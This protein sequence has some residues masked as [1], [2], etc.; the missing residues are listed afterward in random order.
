MASINFRMTD[1]PSSR[2]AYNEMCK[3]NRAID[4][5]I[6]ELTGRLRINSAADDAAGLAIS[7]KCA[8]KFPA[9]KIFR[10][11]CRY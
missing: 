10:Q 7:E 3:I 4:K 1:I 8:E 9:S 11:L 6:D 2:S 5:T